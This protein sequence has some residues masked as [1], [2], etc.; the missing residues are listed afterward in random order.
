MKELITI[1]K[2]GWQALSTSNEAGKNFYENILRDDA[3]MLFPGGMLIAG[4][5]KILGSLGTQPWKSFDIR[6]PEIISLSGNSA[7]IFYKITAQREG[8]PVYKA[9]ISSTY[10]KD[11]EE[12]W[13][14][15]LHQQT[16][17]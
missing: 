3:V 17:E 14:L 11:G 12:N 6:N 5:E 1:E 7:V 9:L 4:K 16:P 2:Q 10:A 15:V 8:S 13:K